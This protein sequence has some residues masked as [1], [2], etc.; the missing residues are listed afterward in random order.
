M[1]S[2]KHEE[3][4]DR[5]QYLIYL[6]NRVSTQELNRMNIYELPPALDNCNKLIKTLSKKTNTVEDPY[7][8]KIIDDTKSALIRAKKN[9]EASMECYFEYLI[10]FENDN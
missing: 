1:A 8:L 6:C 4:Y 5:M 9:I 2:K 10:L 3:Y 7:E